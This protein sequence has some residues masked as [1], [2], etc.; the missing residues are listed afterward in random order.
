MNWFRRRAD[1]VEEEIRS[2]I[3]M[4][5][6]D[7][8]RDGEDPVQ[9]RREVL[10]EFGGVAIQAEDTRAVWRIQWLDQTLADL[11]FAARTLAKSPGF[12]AA[13]ILSLALGVGAT[14][15]LL[16]VLLHVALRPLPYREPDRLAIAWS[17]DPRVTPATSPASFPDWQDWREG[18][19]SFDGIAAFRNRPGFLNV[20]D[21]TLQLE[22]H[23]V[24][25]DFLPLLGVAPALGRF[26][27]EREGEAGQAA[28]ISDGLWRHAFGGARDVVGRRIVVSQT[29]YEIVG[30]MPAGFA[31]PSVGMRAAIRLS[32]ADSMWTPLVPRP[33]QRNNRGNRGLRILTRLHAKSDVVAARRDL[34]AVAA[35]LAAAYPESNRGITSELAPL[36]DSITGAV[37]PPL[38]ALVAAAGL[39]LVIACANVAGLLLARDDSRRREFATRSALG[40]SRGRLIRQSLTESAVLA[41]AGGA[42]GVMLAAALL[43]IARQAAAVLDVPR[44]ADS[45]LDLPV[46]AAALVISGVAA[47]LF[48]ATPASR[49]SHV[50]GGRV[51]ADRGSVRLRQ[52]LVGAATAVT[53]VLVLSATLLVTSFRNLMAD[54]G[55]ANDRTYTFQV[56]LSGTRWARTPLDR[57]FY[58]A[59]LQRV[60]A[61]PRV[62]SAGFTTGLLNIGDSSGTLVSVVGGATLPPDRQ[63]IAG[64]TMADAEFFRLAGLALRAGRLFD[65]RDRDTAP[66][67][68][69]V[70][71]AFVRAVSPD[72]N[73]VGRWVNV[74]GV[75]E[76]PMEVVGVVADGRPFRPGEQER[77]RL[78]YPWM[79]TASTRFIGV[80]RVKEGTPAP[81]EEIRA[82]VREMDATLPVFEVQSVAEIVG[83]ATASPRWGSALV[84]LFAGMALALAAVGVMGTVGYCASQRKKE[85]GIR[86]ALGAAPRAVSW[87]VARQGVWPVL[88][89]LT[90]GLAAARVV[91]TVVG[92]YLFGA[93]GHG[94]AAIGL[95]VAILAVTAGTAALLPARRAAGVD[96]ALTLRCD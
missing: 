37:R 16:S 76:K 71:E 42:A 27:S 6:Q 8:V 55:P 24:S 31:A 39:F 69:V 93:T 13:A 11:R 40:A 73:V 51:T 10:K 57:Q 50:A 36:A 3:R 63:P 67:V 85:C 77:P 70:N 62:E 88:A 47:L 4:A 25:A 32:P 54:R 23:E 96:P 83:K 87:M 46:L 48:G 60:R 61:L 45:V 21:R 41:L 17:M 2:H 9:A 33:V 95:C 59:L 44:L 58:D 86:I 43:A 74:L 28:V 66:P 84:A 89:G 29:A 1:D 56:T 91:E 72:E 38:A 68:A 30:V 82:M 79:Q 22:L 94:V 34:A 78:Y 15:A 49:V 20:G 75:G 35:R 92:R 14:T 64:Y 26:W 7:R 81:M 12:A 5:I 53:F 18:T 80:V 52:V 19:H 65:A 90:A